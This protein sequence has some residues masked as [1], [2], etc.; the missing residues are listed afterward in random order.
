MN[1]GRNSSKQQPSGRKWILKRV[2]RQPVAD[3]DLESAVSAL[4]KRGVLGRAARLAI[5]KQFA[6]GVPAV[7]MEDN[8]I[9]KVYP[10]G[11]KEK[12][13]STNRTATKLSQRRFYIQK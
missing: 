6:Q 5:E 9:Y 11:R 4:A 8:I 12:L 13:A 3:G 10:N 7:W 1:K 2:L